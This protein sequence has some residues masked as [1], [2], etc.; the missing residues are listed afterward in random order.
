MLVKKLPQFVQRQK[1][2]LKKL[3][4][5]VQRQATSQLYRFLAE[6]SIFFSYVLAHEFRGFETLNFQLIASCGA[7]AC[8]DIVFVPEKRPME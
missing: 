6:I 4:Q 7:P 2:L 8:V 5:F 1:K 3:P